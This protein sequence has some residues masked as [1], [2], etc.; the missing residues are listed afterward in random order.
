M[1]YAAEAIVAFS[2]VFTVGASVGIDRVA[3]LAMS[4]PLQILGFADFGLLI[5]FRRE[6]I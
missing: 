3:P 6:L 2:L 1:N 4:K 5:D